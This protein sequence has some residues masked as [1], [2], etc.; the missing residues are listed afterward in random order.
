MRK[1]I[2]Q[3]K[4]AKIGEWSVN[5]ESGVLSNGNQ[6]IDLEPTPLLM[7]KVLIS[8]PGEVVSKNELL[9]RVWQHRVVGDDALS[10][11]I[12]R[13]RKALGD[14]S[15]PPQY[16][17]T[18]PRKGYRLAQNVELQTSNDN[19]PNQIGRRKLLALCLASITLMLLVI[20]KSNWEEFK[21]LEQHSE[22]SGSGKASS[23]QLQKSH[24]PTSMAETLTNK[25]DDFYFQYTRADNEA[26]I[27]LYRQAMAS[28]PNYAPSQSGLA[29]ALV[30]KILRWPGQLDDAPIEHENLLQALND[31]RT[32]T[33]FAMQTLQ[34]AEQL[35]LRSVRLEPNNADIRKAL[36]L[37]YATQSKFELAEKEYEKAI[38]IDPDAWGSMINLSDIYQVRGEHHRSIK[39][40]EKAFEAM[41]RVYDDQAVRV[42]PWQPG[43]G[44]L[45][46][47]RYATLEQYEEAE[48]WFRHVLSL[49]PYHPEATQNLI[50]MILKGGDKEAARLLCE[51]Y[52]SKIG[53]LEG[54][55]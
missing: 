3:I 48:I 42:R 27:D 39:I 33:D 32:K 53:T 13:L 54:C 52:E 8:K 51:E 44:N 21:P 28:Q 38:Q 11:A 7:L 2:E 55:G 30:Q 5:L 43:L 47:E 31:G 18:V 22:N 10:Q 14:N 29:N 17:Q 1:T 50:Q 24:A 46:G 19:P 25:A 45:I 37:V 41:D 36:G 23:D 34:R 15:K 35:A 6:K 9:E 26:A 4:S 49:S 40:L 16:I 12:S 20:L